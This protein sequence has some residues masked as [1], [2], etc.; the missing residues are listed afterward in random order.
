MLTPQDD[1]IGH[2]LPTT[3]DQI[4]NSDPA[5]MERLWYTGH[6]VP[7]G[8]VIFGILRPDTFLTTSNFTTI[9][10]SQAILVVLTLALL[11]PLTAG[12][13]D[14]SVAATMGLSAMTLAITNVNHHWSI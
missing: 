13:Y 12:D 7:A 5:W 14:L 3:F 4:D 9:F 11:V 8:D 10:G 2:Q 6:P 1:L